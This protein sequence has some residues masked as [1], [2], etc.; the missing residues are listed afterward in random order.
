[1][2]NPFYMYVDFVENNGTVTK[3]TPFPFVSHLGAGI[4]FIFL[5]PITDR[6]SCI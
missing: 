3:N 4:F 1:M 2:F 6:P 5:F